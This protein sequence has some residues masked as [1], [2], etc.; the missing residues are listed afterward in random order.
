MNQEISNGL[1][2][3]ASGNNRLGIGAQDAADYGLLFVNQDTPARNAMQQLN[4]EIQKQSEVLNYNDQISTHQIVS[5]SGVM[6][7]A[8]ETDRTTLRVNRSVPFSL[9]HSIVASEDR[10]S[11]Q[12]IE[13]SKFHQPA[14]ALLPPGARQSNSRLRSLTVDGNTELPGAAEQS[15]QQEPLHA[16]H[17]DPDA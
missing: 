8:D 17:T 12:V 15:Q 6:P 9:N 1:D 5:G 2:P 14:T 11:E 7:S 13:G 10:I 3:D 4:F 16:Q